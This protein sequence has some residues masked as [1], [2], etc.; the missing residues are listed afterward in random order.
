MEHN[1]SVGIA[2]S[3]K[4]FLDEDDWHY[5]FDRE[6][7]LFRFG[8]NIKGKLTSIQ[9]LVIVNENDYNV[10]ATSPLS[11]D[12]DDGE[13]M[14]EMAEFVCRANYGLRNGNFELDFRDGELRYKC[15]VNCDGVLPSMEM[16]RSSIH[17]PAAMFTRYGEGIVQILF[18]GV[19]AV[20]AVN[21]CEGDSSSLLEMLHKLQKEHDGNDDEASEDEM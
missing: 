16:V 11:A 14:K 9:Y 15:Y 1:Y 8:L 21:L 5:S 10:Y 6:K 3:I 13:Q 4:D 2:G 18:G 17:C 7:G 12:Q 20:E 19:N